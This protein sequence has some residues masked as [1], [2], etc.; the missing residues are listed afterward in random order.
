M[1]IAKI[2][3]KYTGR[4]IQVEQNYVFLKFGKESHAYGDIKAVKDDPVLK[5]M[6]REARSLGL[7]LRVWFS[8]ST[9]SC[10]YRKN[11]VNVHVTMSEDGKYR[12]SDKFM[13]G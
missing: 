1:D 7:V 8:E 10:H 6:E 3:N 13:I 12:I 9:R 5:N 11:R 2:F 4:E